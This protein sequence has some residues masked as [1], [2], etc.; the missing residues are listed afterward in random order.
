MLCALMLQCRMERGNTK[1]KFFDKYLGPILLAGLLPLRLF[2]TTSP[3]HKINSAALLKTAAIG[4][5][6][7]LSA[8]ITDLRM[9][10]PDMKIVL[11]TGASNYEFS[12][13]LSGVEVVKLPLTNPLAALKLIRSRHFDAFID[14]DSWPRISSLMAALSH[15]K[16]RVGFKTAHQHRHFM[17]DIAVVHRDDQHELENYRDLLRAL[18]IPAF[19]LPQELRHG[20]EKD[21]NNIVFHLWPSGTQSHLREWP[22]EK[23]IFLANGLLASGDYSFVLTGGREDVAKCEM[24]LDALPQS[25]RSKFTNRAGSSFG[26]TLRLLQ[27][28]AL[29]VSVNTGIMHI[30]AAMGVPTVGLH[31]PTNPRRWGPIGQR[32]RSILSS[33]K[34]AASLNL[35]FEYTPETDY[36]G[37]I[38][39]NEV[40]SACCELLKS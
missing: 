24:V 15:A 31:G 30:G 9:A 37:G 19:S 29:L 17:Q 23:W 10:N 16:I 14:F 25:L 11:F 22:V 20:W 40:L 36:M 8:A 38:D 32:T 35:G 33:S 21:G 4:D 18:S 6:V 2:R 12:K 13:L 28:A 39:D 34:G 5:T 3:P 7:L 27:K 1:L 26:E